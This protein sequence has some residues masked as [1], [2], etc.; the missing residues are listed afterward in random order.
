MLPNSN[1]PCHIWILGS[2]SPGVAWWWWFNHL[3]L[4]QMQAVQFCTQP[5]N[6]SWICNWVCRFKCNHVIYGFGV[7]FC[8]DF[9]GGVLMMFCA[10][11]VGKVWPP[12]PEAVCLFCLQHFIFSAFW[13]V[14]HL[15]LSSLFSCHL[16]S[17]SFK[18]APNILS[19][20]MWLVS[21]YCCTFLVSNSPTL[22]RLWNRCFTF[23]LYLYLC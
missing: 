22:L 17:S 5:L 19:Y 20:A 18:S 8:K 11:H 2:F 1:W 10:T 16:Q 23:T 14:D 3:N 13:N 7:I 21:N 4:F 6:S 12:D 15:F 9:N